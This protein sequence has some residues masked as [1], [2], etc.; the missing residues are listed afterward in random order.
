VHKEI[1][2]MSANRP[3]LEPRTVTVAIDLGG[4]TVELTASG[5]YDPEWD[6]EIIEAAEMIRLDKQIERLKVLSNALVVDTGYVS[7]VG[8]PVTSTDEL[9]ALMRW[10]TTGVSA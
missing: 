7:V 3:K 9:G 6:E 10:A 8:H 1:E 2:T 4:E 5:Y